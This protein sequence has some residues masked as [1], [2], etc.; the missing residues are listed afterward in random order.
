MGNNGYI[1]FLTFLGDT[2]TPGFIRVVLPYN[3]INSCQKGILAN[4][5]FLMQFGGEIYKNLEVLQFQRSATNEQADFI[6]YVKKSF[7]SKFG[8]KL[9][10]E[11]DDL[12][13]DIPKYNSAHSFYE[14]FKPNIIKILE[15]VDYIVCSTVELEKQMKKYNKTI[16]IKN[17]L[18]KPL[19]DHKKE[20]TFF[21]TNEKPKIIWTGSITHFS[22]NDE[23]HDFDKKIIEFID[24]TSDKFEWIFFG[25]IPKELKNN[26]NIRFFEWC[27]NYFDYVYKIKEI[28]PDIGI[29]LLKDNTFNRCKSNLKALEYVSLKIPGIYS[30]I[31]PYNE[32]NIRVYN[33]DIFIDQ[34]EKLTSDE[35][36]YNKIKQKDFD[37]LKNNLYW[38]EKYCNEYI[39]KYLGK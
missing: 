23:E 28:N 3:Y 9:F 27:N 21:E 11:L 15:K 4:F 39:R 17:R 30:R 25:A 19:W 32:M 37:A 38:D 16:L 7:Q 8:F 24:K 34:V 10:Y 6:S 12:I 20:K 29:A 31:A 13:T 14:K 36:Y 5:D 33:S 2:Q 22:E 26:Q 35:S 1:R 18:I